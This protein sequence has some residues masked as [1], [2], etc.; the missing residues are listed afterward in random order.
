MHHHPWKHVGRG[1]WAAV[2]ACSHGGQISQI[3]RTQDISI[4]QDNLEFVNFHHWP[5]GDKITSQNNYDVS[6]T[7]PC[8]CHN[9]LLLPQYLVVATTP[10]CYHNTLLLPQ[11]LVVT[12]I[13]CCC[14]NT[15]LLPQHLVVTITP[16][17]CHNT[18]LLLQHRVVVSHLVCFFYLLQ[19]ELSCF[20]FPP[21][22]NLF[23]KQQEVNNQTNHQTY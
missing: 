9:T 8:C 16:C 7:T 12:T 19:N 2:R 18:L 17:C 14:H 5:Y 22:E 1:W 11:H 13:P 15:L 23:K 6:A 3:P 21:P 4:I 10:C 20:Y